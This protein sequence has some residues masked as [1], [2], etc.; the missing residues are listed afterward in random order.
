MAYTNTGWKRSLSITIYKFINEILDSTITENGALSFTHNGIT[1]PEWNSTQI[2]QSTYNGSNGTWDIRLSAFLSYL[3]AKYGVGGISE[4]AGILAQIN[5]NSNKFRLK[6][7]SNILT[8]RNVPT[9]I[10]PLLYVTSEYPVYENVELSVH[11]GS[12]DYTFLIPLGQASSSTQLLPSFD[13]EINSLTPE[14]SINYQ[15]S[16]ESSGRVVLL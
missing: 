10:S 1:Y 6:I 15:Y 7:P 9:E 14:I 2:Q 13:I 4:D 11:S 16:I 3:N 8:V 5:L 12:S